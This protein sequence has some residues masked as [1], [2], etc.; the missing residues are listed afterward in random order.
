MTRK[1]QEALLDAAGYKRG[2][3][4]IRFK[5]KVMF[6]PAR[7]YWSNLDHTQLAAAYL[8]EIGVDVEIDI[9]E[10]AVMSA[11]VKAHAY[12][13]MTYASRGVNYNPLFWIRIKAYSDGVA[14]TPGNQDPV[15]DAMVEAAENAGSRE[16]M[17]E[18]VKKANDYYI[19]QQ[20]TIWGSPIRP[21]FVVYQPWMVGYNGEWTLGGGRSF[22]ILS[23]VWLDSDLRYEMTGTR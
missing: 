23:R 2:A 17:M 22:L 11:R 12:E 16:E 3:D 8:A 4:G 6:S 15:F 10:G 7:T 18:L 14:N 9:V 21:A 19:A 5:T 20:W 13:G 1:G